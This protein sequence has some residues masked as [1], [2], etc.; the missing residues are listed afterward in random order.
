[1]WSVLKK[2]ACGG[3]GLCSQP[4]LPRDRIWPCAQSPDWNYS[5]PKI[6][7][8]VPRVITK[9]NQRVME[10]GLSTKT[11]SFQSIGLQDGCI[12]GKSV[13]VGIEM[14]FRWRISFWWTRVNLN[15]AF[16][17]PFKLWLGPVQTWANFNVNYRHPRLLFAWNYTSLGY[18]KAGL[19]LAR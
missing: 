9:S 16:W 11:E 18:L 3:N 1:M 19:L 5:E 12:S 14:F 8:W 4:F 6:L 17:S 2:C 10:K 15:K 13:E 7:V